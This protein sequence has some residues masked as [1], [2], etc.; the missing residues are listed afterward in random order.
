MTLHALCA[1]DI[2]TFGSGTQA[3]NTVIFQ[4]QKDSTA[5]P[6]VAPVGDLE[7]PRLA[8]KGHYF[9]TSVGLPDHDVVFVPR[10]TA[11]KTSLEEIGSLVLVDVSVEDEAMHSAAL[12]AAVVRHR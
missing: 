3:A 2:E 5:V 6:A 8:Q 12:S 11:S 10:G 4:I 7:F 9:L 1:P